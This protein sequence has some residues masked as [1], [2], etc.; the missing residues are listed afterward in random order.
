MR[1]LMPFSMYCEGCGECMYVGTK[2]NSKC[3]PVKGEDHLGIKIYRFYGRCKNCMHEFIFKT[4]PATS[5]YVLESGGSRSYEAY[6]DADD[7]DANIRDKIEKEKAEEEMKRMD[8][9]DDLM[10]LN[11]RMKS[12]SAGNDVI[13]EWRK[14]QSSPGPG[15]SPGS[16]ELD[17]DEMAELD[18]FLSEKEKKEE[19]KAP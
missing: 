18:A 8:Q 1:M 7:A 3:E 19:V 2:F 4:D 13:A 6:K 15:P 16:E 11:R 10:K 9:L 14:L 5:D 17:D 12:N